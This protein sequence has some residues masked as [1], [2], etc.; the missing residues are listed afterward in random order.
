MTA[1]RVPDGPGAAAPAAGTPAATVGWVLGF[2]SLVDPDDPLVRRMAVEGRAVM[3][4][5]EGMRRT[6]AAGLDNAAAEHDGKH[7]RDA[8]GRRPDVVVAALSADED[9]ASAMNVLALPVDADGLARTDAR[10]RGYERLEVGARFRP[11][12][13]PGRGDGGPAS[14]GVTATRP[15]GD[16][17]AAFASATPSPPPSGAVPIMGPVWIYTAT[18]ATRA[19]TAEAVAEGRAVVSAAY[20]ERVE[21]AFAARGPR[22]LDAYRASTDAPPFPR[23]DL[24]LHWAGVRPGE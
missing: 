19:L 8:D 13:V 5:V 21:E 16:R 22:A 7:H 6:W 9:R 4:T 24:R 23:M 14:G 2:G 1:G 12:P 20:V 11:D 18:A 17:V 3:G 10:E 15:D